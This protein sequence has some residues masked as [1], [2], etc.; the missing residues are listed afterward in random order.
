[1]L[2][3][4]RLAVGRGMIGI[5][6]GELY[7]SATGLGLMINR[8]GSTFQTDTVFVGVVTILVVGLALTEA[9]HRLERRVQAWRPNASA[10]QT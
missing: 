10:Q 7:G 3:G 1:L 2:A 5:I 4:L 9:L 6:V 8:A